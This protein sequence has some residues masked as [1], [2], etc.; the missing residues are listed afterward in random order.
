MT[1]DHHGGCQHGAGVPSPLPRVDSEKNTAG[2]QLLWSLT[3]K[4]SRHILGHYCFT[5]CGFQSKELPLCENPVRDYG[6]WAHSF[7]WTWVCE[8]Y[9]VC[10][11]TPTLLKKKMEW[12]EKGNTEITINKY[13]KKKGFFWRFLVMSPWPWGHGLI[14]SN[15]EDSHFGFPKFCI[16]W[17]VFAGCPSAGQHSLMTISSLKWWLFFHNLLG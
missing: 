7:L 14:L 12:G 10:W 16:L 4:Y 15:A 2:H 13:K 8:P 9:C 11:S 17:L 5:F 1:P 6:K 3:A